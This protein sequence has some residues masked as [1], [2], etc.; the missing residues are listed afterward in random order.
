MT[1]ERRWLAEPLNVATRDKNGRTT[2]IVEGYAARF[3]SWSEDLGGFREVIKRGAF[4]SVLRSDKTDVRALFNHDPSMVLGRQRAG[5]LELKEDERGLFYRVEL[6]D[7]QVARDLVVSMERG[8]IAHSSF[9]FIV[10]RS[11]QDWND[12]LDERTIT[13]FSGLMDVSPVTFPAYPEASSGL[14]RHVEAAHE[15]RSQLRAEHQA[16]MAIRAKAF[17]AKL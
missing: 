15:V 1:V 2:H 6:P 16:R 4:R 10:G 12:D 13:E 3:D 9:A 5:T 8:D 7:T 14:A 17:A 11:G